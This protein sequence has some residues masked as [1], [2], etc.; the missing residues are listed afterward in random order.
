[1]WEPRKVETQLSLFA[2]HPDAAAVYTGMLAVDDTNGGKV[3]HASRDH[4]SGKTWPQISVS[5][6]CRTHI[7]GGSARSSLP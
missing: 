2:K 5:Q 6:L 1:M 3:L 4:L 7:G